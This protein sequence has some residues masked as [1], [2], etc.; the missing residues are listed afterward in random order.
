MTTRSAP[1][2][3]RNARKGL[4]PQAKP[5]LRSIGQGISLGYRKKVA[6]GLWTINFYLGK[7]K[8]REAIIGTADD[9]QD[10]DGVKVLTY[11]QACRAVLTK[12]D[13][14]RQEAKV[15]ASGPIITV[16]SAV[17]TYILQMNAR[18]ASQDRV[19]RDAENRMSTHV[20]S[21][22]IADIGLHRLTEQDL[23]AWRLRRSEGRSEA[24]VRRI[25]GDL[26]A[27]LNAAVKTYRASLPA[28]LA[29]V[30]RYGL[31][32]ESHDQ[33]IA[34]DNA[35][36]PDEDIRKLLDAAHEIDEERGWDGDLFRLV[37]VLAA[38]G[39][40]FS[41]VVRIR[42]GDV[43]ADKGRVMVPVSRKGKGVKG[44]S[45]IPVRIGED[46]LDVLAPAL[47][48]RK[49]SEPLLL[50]WAKEHRKEEG[51]AVWKRAGRTPWKVSSELHPMWVLI[52]E[53][54]GLPDAI[55][56]SF[57]H[58]SIVRA[59]R[60]GLPVR[61][62]AAAHDTSVEMIEASYSRS[63]VSMMDDVAEKALVPLVN[64]KQPAKVVPIRS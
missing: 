22:P 3:T 30:I 47:K 45:H 51:F 6:D 32:S 20:L 19:R 61:W 10:A 12:A 15:K 64:K 35:A 14:W 33:P 63:I 46:V 9:V 36:L 23:S 54:A 18:E 7:K 4:K 37:T 41:Q 40:R 29:A 42:V 2:S 55:P 39:S 58:S 49:P 21:D 13:E 11:E 26:R 44:S 57:R 24:T 52:V 43:Q 34:R 50:R 17:K 60:A 59:L 31:A 16:A 56:Y 27:A 1:L 28:D 53:R 48:G 5:Y 38:T 8:Y 25:S 62:V